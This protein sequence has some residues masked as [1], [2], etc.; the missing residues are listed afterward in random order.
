MHLTLKFIY[1]GSKQVY[2]NLARPGASSHCRVILVEI[3][4]TDVLL[5]IYGRPRIW[6]KK[7][8]FHEMHCVFF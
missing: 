7:S 1:Y 8:N 6:E 3:L 5:F 4:D 2:T